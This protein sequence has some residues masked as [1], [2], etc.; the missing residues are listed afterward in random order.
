MIE[1]KRLNIYPANKEQMQVFI[2][3]Q[4]DDVLKV[5]Y[6]EMLDGCLEHTNQWEWY[7]VWMIELK[8]GTHIGEMC[9][10]GFSHDGITE[11]GYGIL[12]EYQGLG[13]GSEAVSA[14]VDWAFKQSS[15]RQIEAETEENN[16]ASIRVLEK[17]GFKR[18]GIY[19]EEGP[20]FVKM[21]SQVI[22]N[23]AK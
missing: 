19:G 20:R 10:K 15:V 2:D 22:K 6:T 18:N 21:K 17:C 16:I 1:S 12:K 3:E 7:A 23:S 5:A 14:L 9:F 8:D 4:S 13:Y 11:I